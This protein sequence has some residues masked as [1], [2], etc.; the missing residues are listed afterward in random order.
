M[1]K[2]AQNGYNTN[3]AAE[4]FVLSSL[5]QLGIAANLTLGNKKSVD[6][7]VVREAGDALTLDVKGLAGTTSWPVD[8]M[9]EARH[10]HFL[11]FVGYNGKI[12]D[13][14]TGP[15]VYVIPSTAVTPFVYHSPG[16]R[17]RVVQLHRLRREAQRYRDAWQLIAHATP[18]RRPNARPAARRARSR[19]R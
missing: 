4:F 14:R 9:R 1:A 15:E 8:N 6:V 12:G 13:P 18:E 19:S 11:V 16:D 7:V 17:R 3:L 10:D 5:H 2:R